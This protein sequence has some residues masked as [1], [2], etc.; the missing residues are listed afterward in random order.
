M[1]ISAVSHYRGGTIDEVVPLAKALKAAYLNTG[2]GMRI[3]RRVGLNRWWA[4]LFFVPLL[5]LVGL[6]LL[7]WG[8]WPAEQTRAPTK[9]TTR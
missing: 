6:W 5:N 4:L 1:T 2:S 3:L 9:G 8:K 7:A